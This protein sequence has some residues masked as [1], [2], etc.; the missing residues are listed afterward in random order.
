M[1]ALD[2]AISLYSSSEKVKESISECLDKYKKT[3][4][5]IIPISGINIYLSQKEHDLYQKLVKLKNYKFKETKLGKLL[6]ELKKDTKFLK[7]SDLYLLLESL[8]NEKH[9]LVIFSIAHAYIKAGNIARGKAILEQFLKQDFARTI[10]YQRKI[11]YTEEKFYKI[12]Q[13]NLE[14]FDEKLGD[15]KLFQ[16]LLFYLYNHSNKNFKKKL[17]SDFSIKFSPRYILAMSKSIRYGK[18]FPH[19]WAPALLERVSLVE[20]NNYLMRSELPSNIENGYYDDLVFYKKIKVISRESKTLILEHH[21]KLKTA[22]N[23]Y[24]QNLYYELLESPTFY[25]I[26]ISNSKLKMGLIQSAKR[27]LLKKILSRGFAPKY[28]IF[29]L[30]SMG[31]LDRRYLVH[32]MALKQNGL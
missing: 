13:M 2:I 25:Q 9:V 16:N 18:R 24:Y 19:L 8:K 31:D 30:F 23:Y 4:S 21:S 7:R 22:N 20:R 1:T 14:F 12:L 29:K 15:K 5:I 26:V 3:E 17:M 6:L 27:K 28:V 10:F 32:L 11:N